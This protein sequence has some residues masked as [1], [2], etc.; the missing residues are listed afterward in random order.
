M[1]FPLTICLDQWLFLKTNFLKLVTTLSILLVIGFM[2]T[3]LM[4]SDAKC[5]ND[6]GDGGVWN[7]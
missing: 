6:N 3:T 5:G 7:G 1:N 4:I 2:F